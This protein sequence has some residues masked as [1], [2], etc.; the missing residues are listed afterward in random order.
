MDPDEIAKEKGFS[1]LKD[2]IKNGM[3]LIGF[4]IKEA[5][6]G[7][8]I[9]SIEEKVRVAKEVLPSIRV[10]P[11]LIR[12]KEEIKRLSEA[13]KV[14]EDILWLELKKLKINESEENLKRKIA[15]SIEFKNGK[16][17]LEE[18]TIAFMLKNP[19]SVEEFRNILKPENF[20]GEYHSLIVE[21][22]FS[23]CEKDEEISEFKVLDLIED[24][25][26]KKHFT[27]II[28]NVN[29]ESINDKELFS[30]W[31]RE[32]LKKEFE[33]LKKEIENRI[34]NSEEIPVDVYKKFQEVVKHLKKGGC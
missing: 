32:I 6:K 34:S 17:K 5:V 7:R 23:L 30:S 10:I 1:F 29:V 19:E 33:S 16:L 28:W 24:E 8:D 15:E 4:R 20:D 22:I 25:E 12:R 2:M 14:N 27:S 26:A 11:D 13:I 9:S 18:E 3:D 31:K 21:K